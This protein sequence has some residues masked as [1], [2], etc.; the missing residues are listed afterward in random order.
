MNSNKIY[1]YIGSSALI[2]G[3]FLLGTKLYKDSQKKELSFIAKESGEVFV[4]EHSPRYGNKDAKVFLIEF[5]DP[6]CESCRAFYPHVK[7]LIKEFNGKVQLVARYAPFHGNS[8]IAIA[9]L[10]AARKQ[11]KYW[12]SLELL[13][14]RQ[15]EWGSHHHPRIEL[16]FEFLPTLGLDMKK[17]L[18]DMKDPLIDEII[19]Q[20]MEDLKKLGVRGTPTFFV[21]GKTPSGFGYGYLKD[22]IQ[23]EVNRLYP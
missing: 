15:P 2:L 5:L 13:F 11:G 7:S 8:K 10:E 6:E 17:L 9:A 4:R 3:L 23:E 20:D 14:E 16:I 18:K 1:L 19:N 12:E 21:N 22:L